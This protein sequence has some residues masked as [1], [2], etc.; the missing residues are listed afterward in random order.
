MSSPYKTVAIVGAS[1]SLGAPLLERLLKSDFVRIR[2]LKR[3][4]SKSTFP[5][6]VEVVDVDFSS[7]D[8]I[9]EALR[10]QDVLVSTIT[11]EALGDQ[12]KYIDA[13]IA[14]GVK[15]FLPSE[16]GSNL[17]VPSVRR[18]PVYATKV[19]VQDYLAQKAAEGLISYTSFYN[20]VFLDWGVE[21]SFLIDRVNSSITFY[22]DGE[23]EWSTTTLASVADG[24]VGV[25]NHPTETHNR[26]V[27]VHNTVLTQKKLLEVAQKADPARK[28]TI[29]HITIDE[30][31]AKADASVAKGDFTLE[32][33]YAYLARA[34]YDP[35]SEAKFTKLDNKLLGVKEF[36][37]E[38]V[39][40]VVKASLLK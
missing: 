13:A 27:Y 29:N 33:A 9:T 7:L 8:S 21:K 26:A 3:A 17:E 36:S 22:D 20:N 14:A 28:W 19:K 12:I 35:A 40:E 32:V 1:G 18:L 5:A 31:I 11:M 38:E 37:D 30:V 34:V 2:V 23:S 10:G 6:N 25:I 39:F 4:S 16:F 24:V 15:R